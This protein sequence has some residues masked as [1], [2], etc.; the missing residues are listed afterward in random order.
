VQ[1]NNWTKTSINWR[2][3]KLLY[4]KTDFQIKLG[5]PI[6]YIR[7]KKKKSTD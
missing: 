5:D 7:W 4:T 6:N 2:K 3:L 1:L